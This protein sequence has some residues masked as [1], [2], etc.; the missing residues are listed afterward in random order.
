MSKRDI[1]LY[2]D[3]I[4]ESANAINSYVENI[5]FQMFIEDRKTFSATLREYM[6]IG[7]SV[8]KIIEIL[9]ERSPNYPWRMVKDFRNF[10]VHEYFGVNPQIVWD[11][12]TQELKLLLDE[13]YKL[14]KASISSK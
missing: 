6:I 10:I 5:N 11:L 12:T 4:I 3:D 13:I 1:A 2:I 9:E 7:E 14:K 8:G